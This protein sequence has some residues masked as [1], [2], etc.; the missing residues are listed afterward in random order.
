[1]I[2]QKA[3]IKVRGARGRPASTKGEVVARASSRD[4]G[5]TSGGGRGHARVPLRDGPTPETGEHSLER[6][7]GGGRPFAKRVRNVQL[8]YEKKTLALRVRGTE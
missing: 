8:T 7:A 3:Q 1:V 5:R 6:G 4:H 2:R